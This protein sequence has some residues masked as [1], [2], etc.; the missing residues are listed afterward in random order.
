[1]SIL[2]VQLKGGYLLVFHSLANCTFYQRLNDQGYE[3]EFGHSVGHGVGLF[4]HE[5]P[6]VRPG[7]TDEL[8]PGMVITVEPGIYLKGKFGVRIEDMCLVTEK[9][10][11]SFNKVTKELITI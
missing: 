9:G 4:I 6:F 2:R 11:F 10:G 8:K 1:M 5:G 7:G 3:K